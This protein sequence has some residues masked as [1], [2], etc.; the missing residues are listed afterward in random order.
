MRR[1]RNIV[2]ASDLKIVIL[3]SFISDE[4]VNKEI[5]YSIFE[6]VLYDRWLKDANKKLS[7]QVL[8]RPSF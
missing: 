2:Y 8:A 7:T 4:S 5:Q 1:I 3:F 6:A